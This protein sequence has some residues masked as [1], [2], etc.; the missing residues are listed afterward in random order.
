[1]IGRK[2]MWIAIVGTLGIVFTLSCVGGGRSLSGVQILSKGKFEGVASAASGEVVIERLRDRGW[3]LSFQ[4][5]F[6]V[7]DGSGAK[8]YLSAAESNDGYRTIPVGGLLHLG[9]LKSEN[10]AQDYDVPTD[11]DL[12]RFRTVIIGPDGS[13]ENLAVA[14]LISN[15]QPKP[16][17]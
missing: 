17:R 4:E 10:G 9:P 7:E 2:G 1:V 15:G 13:G 11:L 5:N 6:K 14:R 16:G 8:V 12:D 3:I